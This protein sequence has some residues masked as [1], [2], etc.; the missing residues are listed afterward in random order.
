MQPTLITLNKSSIAIQTITKNGNAFVTIIANN[1][2]FTHVLIKRTNFN[3][4]MLGGEI[5]GAIVEQQ[6][7]DKDGNLGSPIRMFKTLKF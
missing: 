1:Q 4:I 5:S 3:A 7:P 2:A 6:L